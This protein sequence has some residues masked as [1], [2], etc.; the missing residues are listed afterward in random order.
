MI[1]LLGA[2]ALLIWGLRLIKT[3]MLRAFGV[4][5]RYWI[6]KSTRNRVW[7]VFVGMLATLAV[8]S[9]TATAVITASFA[10]RDLVSGIMAQAIMLGANIGTSLAAVILTLDLHWLSPVLILVGVI[11]FNRSRYAMGK[12]IGRAVLGLGLMLLA[13]SLMGDATEPVRTSETVIFILASLGNAPVFALLFAAGLAFAA[14]SSLAVV[15]FVVLLGQA[16]IITAEL[17]LVLVA[18]ANLGGALPPYLAVL[19]EGVGARRL[20]AANLSIRAIGAIVLTAMAGIIAPWMS[21]VW[22]DTGD[23]VLAAHIGFSVVLLVVFLPVLGPVVELFKKLFPDAVEAGSAPHYLDESVLTTPALALSAAAR[24]TLRLGDMVRE[25][26]EASMAA[27]KSSDPG[28]RDRLSA[29]E[30]DIDRVHAEI[31]MYLSRLGQEELDEEDSRRATEI[32]AYAVNLEHIGDI[33]DSGLS[34][35]AA[36]KVRRKLAFSEEGFAEIVAFYGRTFEIF[37]IAQSVFLSRDPDLA[38]KLAGCKTD[39]RRLEAESAERHLERLRAQRTETVET[40]GLHL[41]ILRD[42]K[43]VNAH[44]ISV[45]YPILDDMGALRETR[46]R[47]TP[48]A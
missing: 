30:N 29:I 48:E 8:Q 10:A 31:K 26:L 15:L 13:L 44:L 32:M 43:R 38:R 33:I 1:E 9:S 42:L 46:L 24:E 17:A 5:L 39:V 4:S 21:R 34:E 45:A 23:L 11:S 36:K 18:G 22:P 35:L 41:D 6:G 14:T 2:G 12:G 25:M 3:G 7:A 27:L 19:R 20:A 47:S 16:G 28:L 40:S 37:Q